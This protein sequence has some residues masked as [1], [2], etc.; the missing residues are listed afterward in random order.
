MF[1]VS[2]FAESS[3]YCGVEKSLRDSGLVNVPL[4]VRLHNC[5]SLGLILYFY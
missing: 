2:A 4:T 3:P 5:Y 1:E